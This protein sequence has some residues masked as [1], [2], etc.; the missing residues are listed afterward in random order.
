MS[1]H[2]GADPAINY[3]KLLFLYYNE[4]ILALARIAEK[5]CLPPI[6]EKPVFFK[7]PYIKNFYYL[8]L[9]IN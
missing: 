9:K 6:E 3:H 5:L 7:L 4:F 2:I 1:A 8:L